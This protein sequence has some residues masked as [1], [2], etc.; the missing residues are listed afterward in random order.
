MGIVCILTIFF[1]LIFIYDEYTVVDLSKLFM[2]VAAVLLSLTT[3]DYQPFRLLKNLQT[4]V[5]ENM[6]D[7]TIIY[8]NKGSILKIN[9]KAKNLFKEDVISNK[10]KLMAALK[11]DEDTGHT[12]K[13]IN[14]STYEVVYKP[15]YDSS[16][17]VEDVLENLETDDL[18]PSLDDLDDSDIVISE[19]DVAFEEDVMAELAELEK[20]AGISEDDK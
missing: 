8:D 19:E 10:D 20:L 4:Y 11:L 13:T 1:I 14:D 16:K 5:D 7:A 6:S 17:M 2:G 3:F 18:E 9:T 15:E 12:I